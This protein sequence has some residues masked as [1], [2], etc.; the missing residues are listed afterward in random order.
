MPRPTLSRWLREARKRG[1]VNTPARRLPLVE[2]LRVL[3][4][5][6]RLDEGRRVES[7]RREGVHEA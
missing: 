7:L 5:A 6:S 1:V 4:E 3:I 2:K